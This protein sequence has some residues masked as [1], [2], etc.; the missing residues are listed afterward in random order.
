MSFHSVISKRR[1]EGQSETDFVRRL[2]VPVSTFRNWQ[3]TEPRPFTIYLVAIALGERPGLLFEEYC[4][5]VLAEQVKAKR[6]EEK[7]NVTA[8][9]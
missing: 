8:T 3:I 1:L 2:G 5:H 6:E 7:V 4:K 9:G